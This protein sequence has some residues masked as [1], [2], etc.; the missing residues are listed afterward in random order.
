MPLKAGS[1]PGTIQSNIRELM[2]KFTATGAIGTS[3]P[4]SVPAAQK[5]ASAIAYSKAE[6]A[7]VSRKKKAKSSYGPFAQ[8]RNRPGRPD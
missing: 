1:S 8:L 3:T 2:D 5:Q 4:P 7:K 6:E